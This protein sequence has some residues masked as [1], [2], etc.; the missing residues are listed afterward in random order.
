M[1]T[2]YSL[3][4]F[5]CALVCAQK[6]VL[7]PTIDL[8]SGRAQ[9]LSFVAQAG[10]RVEADHGRV[11]AKRQEAG[12]VTL[13]F[14]ALSS[15]ETA[16]LFVD[17][18]KVAHLA[19]HPAKLLEGIVADCRLQSDWPQRLGITA[20]HSNDGSDSCFF[21]PWKDLEQVLDEPHPVT[22]TFVVFTDKRDFPLDIPQE[23][24]EFTMGLDK[25]KGTLGIVMD[26]RERV[27]DN[28]GGGGTHVVAHRRNGE[29]LLLLPPEFD[30][31]DVNHILLIRKEI[32]P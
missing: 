6:N 31:E 4:I 2:L 7:L 27:I 3:L 12:P 24:K 9:R 5:L 28:T 16:T 14:P 8:W 21:L 15:K 17:G 25:G 10:W 1:K 30:W 26:G 19:I 23:W 20:K 11:L 29:K 22:A 13:S 18:K 32:E